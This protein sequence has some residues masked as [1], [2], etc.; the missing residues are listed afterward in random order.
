MKRRTAIQV[1][2]AAVLAGLAQHAAGQD[3]A[4]RILLRNAW[5]I[6]N[7]GDIAHAVGMLNLISSHLP[8]AEVV[9]WAGPLDE[10]S[11]ALY[12]Q[13]YPGIEIVE[14]D[15]E[16]M[17]AAIFAKCDFLVHGSAAGFVARPD[18]PQ[19]RSGAP[20][21]EDQSGGST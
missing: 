12:R 5:Q 14:G 13:V 15:D 6:T 17:I 21:G 4:P 18:P 16:A 3:R 11:R 7:I 19:Y 2:L 20:I 8:G 9:L 10:P 1:G